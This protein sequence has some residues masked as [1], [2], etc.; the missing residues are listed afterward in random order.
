MKVELIHDSDCP[1]IEGARNLIRA[2]YS[3][4]KVSGTWLEH[5]RQ[6]PGVPAYVRSYGSP[7]ILVN[8]FDVMPMTGSAAD[9]CRVYRDVDGK[10]SGLPPLQSLLTAFSKAQSGNIGIRPATIFSMLAGAPALLP[11]LGCA[12]CWPAYAALLSAAGIGFV[13]YTPFLLPLMMVFSGA[14]LFGLFLRAHNRAGYGPFL[15]GIVATTAIF[16]GRFWLSVPPLIYLGATAFVVA[17]IWNLRARPRQV[18]APVD[19]DCQ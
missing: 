19:C 14:G 12:G 2:A 15:L 7:T 18:A 16:A 5:C 6:N 9:S 10:L 13:N 3:A 11:A 8:G 17:A 4:G 1:N